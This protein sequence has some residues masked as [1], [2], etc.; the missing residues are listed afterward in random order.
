MSFTPSQKIS[1]HQ[2]MCIASGFIAGVVLVIAMAVVLP[3]GSNQM[4]DAMAQIAGFA[5]LPVADQPAATGPSILA[6]TTVATIAAQGGL[7]T[8]TSAQKD[9]APR[10]SSSRSATESNNTASRQP[11]AG[12]PDLTILA[13][14]RV[15]DAAA[16]S[17]P[18]TA[19]VMID[20][21]R[22]RHSRDYEPYLQQLTN[23]ALDR[24]WWQRI[25]ELLQARQ[26]A[27]DQLNILRQQQTSSALANRND[28][29]DRMN[30]WQ[31][32]VDNA[33][34]DLQDMRYNTTVKPDLADEPLMRQLRQ[35]RDAQAYGS[36]CAR[37]L[38][39][40]I[41]T[42]GQTPWQIR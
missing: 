9:P 8:V 17:S 33:Q 27:L 5:V 25:I 22:L 15:A 3:G 24:L 39:S 28:L 29:E 20:E 6:Q 14:Q 21:F 31:Q 30:Q 32:K 7:S 10:S 38:T 12:G 1:G 23:Q 35:Q 41:R 18:A 34:R 26:Q 16:N 37:T 13:W 2:G 19:I 4:I 40:I 11:M 42:R 36:W